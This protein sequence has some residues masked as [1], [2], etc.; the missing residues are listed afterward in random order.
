MP[1]T[2]SIHWDVPIELSAA[3]RLICKRLT[4]TGRLFVFLREHRHELFDEAFEAELSAMYSEKPRGTAPKPPAMLAMVT[5]LQAYERKSDAAAVE[6]AV[7]DRRWQMVLDCYG[8]EKPPFSQG[9]LVEFRRRLAAHDLDRRLVERTVELAQKTGAFSDKALRVALD[10][11]PLWGAGRVEDTFNLIGHTLGLV[12]QATALV[13]KVPSDEVQHR[14]GLTL[15]KGDSLKADLDIDW[16]DAVAQARALQ[17]VVADVHSLQR[18]VNQNVPDALGYPQLKQAM[19]LLARVIEQDLEPDPDGN[20]FRIKTGTARDRRIS[21]TDPDMRHGRKSKSRV[22]NGFKRHV[23]RDLDSGMILAV[24]VRPANE[25][26]QAAAAF[27]R[28]EV[29]AFGEVAELHIDRGYLASPWT[30]ELYDSGKRILAKPWNPKNGDRF[31]KREFGIDLALG[32]VVCPEGAAA[33]IRGMTAK[34]SKSD[35]TACPSRLR[36][37]NAARRSISIHERSDARRAACPE[38]H[39]PRSR[40]TARTRSGRARPRA[41]RPAAR[42]EGA[43]PRAATQPARPTPRRSSREPSRHRPSA[44]R[45]MITNSVL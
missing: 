4:N 35:C 16:D 9:L 33:P 17:R 11:A 37:T 26:E 14:A 10:S 6:E 42:P 25:P 24:A 36:C 30:R 1:R 29:E 27:L 12:V 32:T 15:L 3:D 28:P 19:E 34:F 2:T 39:I 7:F 40:S 5:L 44:A 23:V 8:C 41:R 18:W 38:G 31:T 13:L 43:L 22:I 21:V 20:G 45:R